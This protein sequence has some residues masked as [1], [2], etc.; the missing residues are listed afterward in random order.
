VSDRN[1][2]DFADRVKFDEVYDRVVSF[3]IDIAVILRTF[4]VVFRGTGY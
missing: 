4:T 3:P 1:E 2:C